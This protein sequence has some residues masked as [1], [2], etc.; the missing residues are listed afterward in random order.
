MPALVL[1]LKP[2]LGSGFPEGEFL[3]IGG[4]L[5]Y[6]HSLITRFLF[7]A[8]DRQVETGDSGMGRLGKVLVPARR[9]E[10]E[11]GNLR[12]QVLEPRPQLALKLFHGRLLGSGLIFLIFF[13]AS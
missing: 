12:G 6:G 8:A 3:C 13:V 5:D 11:E 1:V 2:V 4:R 10:K 7:H 9:S